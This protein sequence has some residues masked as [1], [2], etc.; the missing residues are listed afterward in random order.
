MA[1]P[2]S[3]TGVRSDPGRRAR[4]TGKSAP[5]AALFIGP[6]QLASDQSPVKLKMPANA[7]KAL[8][9]KP[10]RIEALLQGYGDA[11][12]SSR[13][14]G[15]RVSFRIDVDPQ[16]EIVATPSEDAVDAPEQMMEEAVASDSQLEAALEAARE[17][18]RLRAAEILGGDDMLSADTFAKMLGTTRMTVNTKRQSGHILGLDGAKRGF[19]FPVWQLDAD[20][21]PFAELAMLHERLGGPWAVYRFLAAP[22]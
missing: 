18:G 19:R 22:W 15:R 17:R 21:K 20:G 13:K 10:G 1:A 5:T 16:G 6:D 12:A 2:K 3:K 4:T 14:A 11:I 9:Q 7:A 8:A